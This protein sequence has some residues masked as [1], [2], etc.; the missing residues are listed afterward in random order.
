[1]K[2]LGELHSTLRT[3]EQTDFGYFFADNFFFLWNRALRTIVAERTDNIGDTAGLFALAYLAES[4]AGITA[5]DS[6]KHYVFWRPVTAIQQG[7][8]DGNPRTAG[9]PD[10][11]PLINT[12]N[13][14]DYTSGANN[15]TGAV[16]R[17]RQL[18]FGKDKLRLSLTSREK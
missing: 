14:P 12:P 6:K 4:D 16:T 15:V 5:W 10:W 13:Y 2:A 17:I 7:D 18:L 1:M 3:P 8:D 11:K 9:D